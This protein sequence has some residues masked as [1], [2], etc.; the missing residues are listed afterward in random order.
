M[1][2]RESF[3]RE[4][5]PWEGAQ[6]LKFGGPDKKRNHVKQNHVL[7]AKPCHNMHVIQD[8]GVERA[9]VAAPSNTVC[10]V[11]H[12]VLYDIGSLR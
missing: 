9:K 2:R 10:L 4:P 12:S 7:Q 8:G 5:R 1:F 3:K 6:D 11:C